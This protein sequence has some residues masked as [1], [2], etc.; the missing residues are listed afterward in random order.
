VGEED[1][2]DKP[3]AVK[4]SNAD[5]AGGEGLREAQLRSLMA[6]DEMVGTIMKRLG[7]LRE[8]KR[9]LVFFTSDNGYFWAEHG[10]T[11]KRMPYT[12]AI[13]VPFYAR[14]PG[15]LAAGARDNRLVS[16]VDL[17]PTVLA[18]AGAAS[19]P[20]YPPDGRSLLDPAWERDRVLVEY[21]QDAGAGSIGPW[22]SVRTRDAQYV[23]YYGPDGV[24]VE[25]REY[26]DLQDDPFQL[27]NLLGDT[28]PANDPP[29]NELQALA[30]ALAHDRSCQGTSGPNACP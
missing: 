29:P 8:R 20:A 18:A 7:K 15:R 28:N 1:K 14:W 16:L 13:N 11:D 22:G 12:E 27:R 30:L 2:S 24:T 10:L 23:E 19:N 26:Y 25:F 17:A 6:V 9:T 21:F 4:N 5:E 3:N